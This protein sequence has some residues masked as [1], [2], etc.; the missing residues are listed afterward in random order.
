MNIARLALKILMFFLIFMFTINFIQERIC[1]LSFIKKE[2]MENPL[3]EPEQIKVNNNLTGYG[4][5]LDS[6]TDYVI[7]YFGGNYNIAYNMVGKY[8]HSF[9]C[10]FISVDYYGTQESKGHINLK[11]MKQTAL[12]TYDY[13][14]NKYPN[15]K[16]CVIGHS[17]GTGMA[18]YLSSQR[19]VHK[20][21]VVSGFRDTADIYNRTTPIFYGPLKVFISNNIKTKEYAKNVKNKTYVIGSKADKTLPVKMQEELT[22][23]FQNAELKLFEDVEHSNY[24]KSK[25]VVDFIIDEIGL[26][27]VN[28]KG[29]IEGI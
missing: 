8:A 26:E 23:A 4:Y 5:R 14:Q 27:H 22:K 20:L 11:T 13:V 6:Q 7:I 19:D 25:D 18:T 1:Y 24:F 17:Y 9:D 12:D 3:V 15:K 16:V 21:F 28:D 2:K 29:D 10:A